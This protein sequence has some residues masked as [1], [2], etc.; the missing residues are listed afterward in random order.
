MCASLIVAIEHYIDHHNQ[1]PKPFSQTAKAADI[2]EKVKRA[3]TNLS[4][5]HSA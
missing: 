3:Q 4:N 1:A 2:L 5:Q